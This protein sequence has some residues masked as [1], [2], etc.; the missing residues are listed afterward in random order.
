MREQQRKEE[1]RLKGVISEVEENIEKL[2]NEKM[3]SEVLLQ[4]KVGQKEQQLEALK[5]EMRGQL[6]G[7]KGE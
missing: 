2:R 5:E 3:E 7:A 1:E 4:K 6:E